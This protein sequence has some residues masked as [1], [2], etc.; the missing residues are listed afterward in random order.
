MAT[1]DGSIVI[2]AM[3]AIFRGI[4]L[5][6]QTPGNISYL[7]WMIIGYL[8]VTAVA[9]GDARP[10]R[11]H[12]RPG[13]DLQPRLRR[14]H[15]WPRSRSPWTRSPAARRRALADRLA[16]SMQAF[17]GAMLMANAAAILTD[18]FPAR[19]ARHGAGHQPDLRAS[20]GQLDRPAARRPAGR[21]STGALVFWVNV[22]I[23]IF[24]TILGLQ[25]ACT[26]SPPPGGP[27]S[28]GAGNLTFA[29]RRRAAA[30]RHHLRHPA[31]RRAARPGG[32]ARSCSAGWPPASPCC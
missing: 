1:I 8:L 23:G 13:A 11:R 18:A 24:G 28:T 17:G 21:L 22:P 12:L 6:P 32:P 9:G 3:P 14:L 16:G 25:G 31:L 26:R 20:P 7:L 27:G 15:R 30:G 4:H 2:I 29:A 5:D 19:Q 10:S